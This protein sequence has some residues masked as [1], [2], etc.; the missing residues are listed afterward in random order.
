[1]GDG[2]DHF[3]RQDIEAGLKLYDRAMLI[4]FLLLVLF[5][6]AV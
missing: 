5:T 4:M 3:L 6:F 2:R 1:M